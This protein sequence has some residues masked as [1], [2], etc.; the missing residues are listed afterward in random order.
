M[1]VSRVLAQAVVQM[2]LTAATVPEAIEELLHLVAASGRLSEP[3][4]LAVE[5]CE[6]ERLRQAARPGEASILPLVTS[7]AR[8]LAL[9]VGRSPEGLQTDPPVHL[10][11]ILLMPPEERVAGFRVLNG[12]AQLM[13]DQAVRTRLLWA[14]SPREFVAICQEAEGAR[15]TALAGRLRYRVAAWLGTSPARETPSGERA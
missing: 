6:R 11:C 5:L 4:E 1:M 7:R 9:A 15:W 13:R 14:S 10:L 12:L 3:G 8:A 2:D